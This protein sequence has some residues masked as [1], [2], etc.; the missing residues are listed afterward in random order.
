MTRQTTLRRATHTPY[1]QQVSHTKREALNLIGPSLY[2]IWLPAIQAVKIGHSSNPYNRLKSITSATGGKG[3]L[4]AI[5]PG[6][7]RDD[8]QAI[9]D[10]LPDSDRA[11][12][13]EYYRPTPAVLAVVNKMRAAIHRPPIATL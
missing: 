1:V 6:S 9:H 12:G 13:R 3:H 8:E 2:A 7:T 11:K 5:V 4:L 10:G